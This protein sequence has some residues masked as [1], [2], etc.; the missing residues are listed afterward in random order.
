VAF[1][2]LTLAAFFVYRRSKQPHLPTSEKVPDQPPYSIPSPLIGGH[3]LVQVEHL[4]TGGV[5]LTHRLC[6]RTTSYNCSTQGNPNTQSS[7]EKE[8]QRS[9]CSPGNTST[10]R[11]N[12]PT[13]NVSSSTR[14]I[15]REPPPV[16][17]NSTVLAAWASTNR[18]VVSKDME[19]KLLAAGYMPSDNPDIFSEDEWQTRCG[20][21]RLE[22][23]RLR[24]LYAR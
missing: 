3:N 5:Q 15:P 1:V 4:T 14:E 16:Y 6:R 10:D 18:N 21:T 23:F 20:I 19:S 8:G 17:G 13:P 22:L 24:K 9:L 11:N 12:R 2:A 7:L